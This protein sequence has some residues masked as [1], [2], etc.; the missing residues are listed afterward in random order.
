MRMLQR[1]ML[2][3]TPSAAYG[4]TLRG[5]CLDAGYPR[6]I[7]PDFRR[8]PVRNLDRAGVALKF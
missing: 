3:G 1:S 2:M 5:A 7:P 4:G 6:R 8:T